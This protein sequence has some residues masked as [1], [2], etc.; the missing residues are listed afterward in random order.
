VR[1]TPQG[2]H[3]KLLE[4]LLDVVRVCVCRKL[5]ITIVISTEIGLHHGADV[6]RAAREAKRTWIR[7]AAEMPIESEA[8]LFVGGYW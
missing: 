1:Q 3:T 6:A 8:E 5:Q 7:L 4:L 2:H